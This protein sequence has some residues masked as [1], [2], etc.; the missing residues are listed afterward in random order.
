MIFL[1]QSS[2]VLDLLSTDTFNMRSLVP[3]LRNVTQGSLRHYRL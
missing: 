3:L 1:K 2:V